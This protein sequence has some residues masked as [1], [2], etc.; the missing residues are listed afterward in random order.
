MPKI[1]VDTD[2]ISYY[3]KG[4][5][6]VVSKL[7]EYEGKEGPVFLSRLTVVEILGGLK[8]KNAVKQEFR[9]RSWLSSRSILEITAETG[10]IAA[11][12]IAHLVQ[13]GFHS[14]S[15]DVLIAATAIQN[16]LTLCTNNVKDYQNFFGLN[17]INWKG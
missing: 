11:G 17:L 10:E 3:F 7:D 6:D 8:A 16:N 1:L 2:I 13:N 9:F 12:L 14:G 15:Y 4:N 5:A